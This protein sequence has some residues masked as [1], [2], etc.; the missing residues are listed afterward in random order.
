MLVQPIRGIWH[1]FLCFLPVSRFKLELHSH[2]AILQTTP[3]LQL[4]ISVTQVKFVLRC[5]FQP[6]SSEFLGTS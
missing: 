5:G 6:L 3:C 4:V 2:A 1:S